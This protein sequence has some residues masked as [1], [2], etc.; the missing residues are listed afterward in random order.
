LAR[1]VKVDDDIY[2]ASKN[3]N[4]T[5]TYNNKNPFNDI[6][7]HSEHVATSCSQQQFESSTAT[8]SKKPMFFEAI[9][10]DLKR[11]KQETQPLVR[12]LP[13]PP[14]GYEFSSRQREEQTQFFEEKKDNNIFP[15]DFVDLYNY[16]IVA[17][18]MYNII[19]FEF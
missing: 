12:N 2:I 17:V 13:D 3:K 4:N 18:C 14:P 9:V 15:F 7:I 10:C 6:T 19:I 16:S 1:Y 5:T 11:T 8:T